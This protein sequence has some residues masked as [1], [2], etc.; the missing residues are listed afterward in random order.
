MG[1]Y[2]RVPLKRVKARVEHQCSICGEII[3]VGKY[4]YS[5]RDRF[6]QS[7]HSKDF[8]SKCYQMYGEAVSSIDRKRKIGEHEKSKRLDD[9]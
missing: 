9:F 8:C 5:R 3:G 6:L 1:K 4:F 2:E 7:L